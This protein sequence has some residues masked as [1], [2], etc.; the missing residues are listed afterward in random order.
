[1]STPRLITQI[2]RTCESCD[3]A[4]AALD[5]LTAQLEGL[6]SAVDALMVCLS[7]EDDDLRAR[8]LAQLLREETQRLRAQTEPVRAVL[9]GDAAE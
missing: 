1:M 4:I 8:C 9:L 6:T 3:Q 5:E 2:E 7:V